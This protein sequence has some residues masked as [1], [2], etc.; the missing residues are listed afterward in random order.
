[1]PHPIRTAVL[2]AAASRISGT[3]SDD[4]EPDSLSFVGKNMQP[5]I[6]DATADIT[7]SVDASLAI[8]TPLRNAAP[9][10]REAAPLYNAEP[11]T[12]VRRP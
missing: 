8:P 11:Q 12:A 3:D 9:T 5:H 10:A 2:F 4:I 6:F 1:M 7:F